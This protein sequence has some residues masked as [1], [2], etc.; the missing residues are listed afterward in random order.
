M[1]R[2]NKAHDILPEVHEETLSFLKLFKKT[3]NFQPLPEA[4]LFISTDKVLE[5]K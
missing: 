3:T 5:K 1:K 4:D 2:Y